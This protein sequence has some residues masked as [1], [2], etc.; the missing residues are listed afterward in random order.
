MFSDALRRAMGGDRTGSR[1][2][3]ET[4]W[5]FSFFGG[6]LLLA[7]ACY[8]LDPVFMLGQA[9]GLVIYSRNLYFIWLGK[10]GLSPVKLV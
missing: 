8:R 6:A 3:P 7:Y 2:L 10:R 4:F 5:Y 9:T 1:H